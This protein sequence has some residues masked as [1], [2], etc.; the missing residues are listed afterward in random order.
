MLQGGVAAK[1]SPPPNSALDEYDLRYPFQPLHYSYETILKMI[2]PP[3]L[4]GQLGRRFDAR[5]T[6]FPSA[7]CKVCA[8][9]D[10][11]FRT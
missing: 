8:V 10:D 5:R 11:T 7:D 3:T 9:C 2:S 1:I 4:N 6:T